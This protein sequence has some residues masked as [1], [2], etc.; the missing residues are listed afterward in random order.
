[1]EE[2]DEEQYKVIYG[3]VSRVIV[4]INQENRLE[5]LYNGKKREK[6]CLARQLGIKRSQ[7]NYFQEKKRKIE[8]CV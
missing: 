6:K 8:N 2:M 3:T 7:M 1:M 4:T 5:H